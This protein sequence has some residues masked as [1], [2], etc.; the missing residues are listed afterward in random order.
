MPF[1]TVSVY[2]PSGLPMA[3]AVSPTLTPDESA[4]RAALRPVAS[5]LI[6]A[7]SLSVACSTSV[8]GYVC[9]SYSSTL[10]LVLPLIDVAVGQDVAVR[11]QDDPGPDARVGWPNGEKRSVVMPS[12]VIVTTDSLALRDDRGEVVGGDRRAARAG[13]QGR[14]RGGGSRGGGWQEPGD[15]RGGPAGGER[16]AEHGGGEHGADA[17]VAAAGRTPARRSRAARRSWPTGRT[18]RRVDRGRRAA[19]S[20]PA[21][22]ERASSGAREAVRTGA[23]RCRAPG[24]QAG[25][26]RSSGMRSCGAMRID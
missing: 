9:P 17:A 3:M 25:T 23:D 1:V 13:G 22:Q 4:I 11:G 19:S 14:R 10:R 5:I 18:R 21:R 6:R 24:P 15:D 2:V 16:R 8:A 7:R 26:V 12:A 20:G